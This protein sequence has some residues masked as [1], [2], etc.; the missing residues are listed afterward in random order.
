GQQ[1]WT[2]TCS[3]EGSPGGDHPDAV[4]A[5]AALDVASEP[6]RPVRKDMACTMIYGGAQTATVQGR[7]NG[8]DVLATF[9]RTDGCEIARWDRVAPLVQPGTT[10]RSSGSL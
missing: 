4:N 10:G 2:L 7:W 8:Q 6:F 3:V 9:K 1:T 5:C